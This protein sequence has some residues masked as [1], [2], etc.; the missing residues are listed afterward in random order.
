MTNART[1]PP[2]TIA[3]NE[4]SAIRVSG[5]TRGTEDASADGIPV[6]SGNFYRDDVWYTMTAPDTASINGYTVKVYY[7]GSGTDITGF[8]IGLYY[9]CDADANNSPFTCLNTP[10]EDKITACIDPGQTVYIRVWS[11]GW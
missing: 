11:A 2:I 1:L 9:S 4:A 5:D 8:G 10:S 7:S 6:C 3:V